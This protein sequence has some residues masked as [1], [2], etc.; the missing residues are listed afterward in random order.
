MKIKISIQS[1]QTIP[2]LNIPV[3]FA[4]AEHDVEYL[5]FPSL[6]WLDYPGPQVP[7]FYGDDGDGASSYSWWWSSFSTTTEEEAAYPVLV[8]GSLSADREAYLQIFLGNSWRFWLAVVGYSGSR[9]II[10]QDNQ[11]FWRRSRQL[12][13][14]L[15]ELIF[16]GRTCSHARWPVLLFGHSRSPV[17]H[18]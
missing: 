7:T 10:S 5:R 13:L 1:P 18:I 15:R 4:T 14:V 6:Q 3:S 17:L 9:M 11:K 8:C 16:Q 12:L 2:S